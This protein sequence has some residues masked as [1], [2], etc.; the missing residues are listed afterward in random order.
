MAA[1]EPQPEFRGDE[2]LLLETS[3]LHLSIV[4]AST[5]GMSVAVRVDAEWRTIATAGWAQLVVVDGDS[6]PDA[7]RRTLDLVPSSLERV[8]AGAVTTT[9]RWAIVTLTSIWRAS[10]SGA[11]P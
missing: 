7:E 11:S 5:Q 3:V 9:R 8:D 2:P 4:P 6:S 10:P 1:H